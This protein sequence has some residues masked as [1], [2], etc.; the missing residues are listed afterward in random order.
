MMKW[1][2]WQGWKMK[3]DEEEVGVESDSVW[4]K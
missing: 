2:E 3:N 1:L 4:M